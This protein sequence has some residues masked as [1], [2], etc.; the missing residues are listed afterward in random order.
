MGAVFAA[1]F[2]E[3]FGGVLADEDVAALRGVLAKL[4]AAS[5]SLTF[6]LPA[7]PAWLTLIVSTTLRIR[8]AAR[9]AALVGFSRSFTTPARPWP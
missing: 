2:E 8:L 7:A 3:R 5:A 9:L 6:A 4:L 1:A